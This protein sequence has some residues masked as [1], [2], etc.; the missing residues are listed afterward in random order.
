IDGDFLLAIITAYLKEKQL[1]AKNRVVVTQMSNL[2]FK[3]AM[4]K[5]GVIVEETKVGDRYVL[6]RMQETGATAGGEQSGHLILSHYNSTGDGPAAAL[7]LLTII[8]ESGQ[9]LS[10]LSQV[11]ERLPQVLVNVQVSRKTGWQDEQAIVSAI[12]AAETA[13]AGQGRVLLRPSGTEPVIRVMA[14]GKNIGELQQLVD[15]IATA[16]AEK[17]N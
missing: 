15:T 10:Q 9:S 4:E 1:L 14:E 13:L 16:V 7:K 5:L 8:T 17:M 6:E 3:L 12:T 11:M 2:G